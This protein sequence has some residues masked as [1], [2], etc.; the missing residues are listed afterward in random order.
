M[1]DY[2]GLDISPGMYQY[3]TKRHSGR[4]PWGSGDD[5]YQHEEHFLKTIKQMRANGMTEK[6]IWKS[7]GMT[8]SQY[9]MRIREANNVVKRY[10]YEE[11]ARLR[12]K[13]VSLQAIASRF[14]TNESSVRGWLNED[15]R[16]RVLKDK[17]SENVE[18]LKKDLA[19]KGGY[20]QI[21]SGV[22]LML[23]LNNNQ[24]RNVLNKLRQDGYVDYKMR[25]EQL[26]TG[27]YTNVQVLV[28]PNTSWAE[29]Q[30][31]MDKVRIPLFNSEDGGTTLRRIEPP[32]SVDSKRVDIRYAEQGGAEQDGMV[33]LRRGVDDISLKD[34]KYAQ[35]RIAVDGTHYIKGVAVY[36]DDK[37]FPPG[38]DIIFCTNKHEGT[39]MI[40]NSSPDRDKCVLKPMKN[41]P[42]N[43]FGATIKDDRP[44]LEKPLIRAQRHYIDA[45]GKEQ[46][47]CLNI[48]SEEGDR[49][50]WNNKLASQFLGKQNSGLAKNQ[51]KLSEQIA[52]EEFNELKSLTN[53]AVREKLMNEFAD[54]CDADAVELQA[55]GL[56][57]QS[58]ACIL[59]FPS[60]KEN[61]IYAPQ[62]RD[63]EHVALVRYPHGGIFEIPVCTVNNRNKEA[64]DTLGNVIDAVGI[65]KKTADRLSG[66]DFDGDTVLV[67]P[68]DITNI[69]TH[70]ALE[71]LKNFDPKTEYPGYEGMHVMTKSEKGRAMGDV[72]NLITDMTIKGAD[73][74]EIAAATRHSMVVIDAEKHKLDYQKSYV[75]NHIAELK[76]LYQGGARAGAS[77]LLSKSTSEE[78]VDQR[79]EKPL[80]RMTPEERKLY[81]EGHKIFEKTGDTYNAPKPSRKLMTAEEKIKWDSKDK[82]K[83]QE[84]LN[85]MKE[86]GDLAWKT[87]KKQDT[88]TKMAET[89]DAYTLVS[90]DS[91]GSTT[92]IE[93]VYADYANYMKALA[94]E[95]RA[96]ARN[97]QPT[98][99]SPSARKTYAV[100]V[101]SLNA[102]LEKA[103]LNSPRERQAMIKANIAYRSKVREDPTMDAEHKKRLKGQELDAARRM[104]G[105]KKA[106]IAI[107][108]R[109]WEA[110]T[111]GA[112]KKSVVRSILANA[113]PD[114]VKELAM[115]KNAPLMTTGKI[116]KAKSMLNAGYSQE[117]IARALGVSRST[118]VRA[119]G[120]G[121]Y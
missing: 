38:K 120:I 15:R 58:T 116:A 103:K 25:V 42:D 16:S 1:A 99:Y 14:N 62:Y 12:A 106:T 95:A 63:G 87:V 100:E 112:F 43:P 44:E 61:D 24:M 70:A 105:A 49:F 20:L 45:D 107:T 35:V 22:D 54:K 108:D 117:D 2:K 114:R 56:P 67:I 51:L 11:A 109:E 40:D 102:K 33:L 65:N 17:V 71:G 80:F 91:D 5:P 113:N 57:R 8:S 82:A 4:Y 98:D 64:A 60:I 48:V 78:H 77:T 29:V 83:Q 115:P 50:N 90:R 21:G 110:I 97:E 53:S 55:A 84:V 104:V 66:A 75:D 47:S 92:R 94:L 31:N 19:E 79:E 18:L 6:D 28:P 46:L 26:G 74:D 34:A 76:E 13:G 118:L 121:E 93:R 27:H 73:W 101:A 10:K 3:G 111:M 9:R 86:R 96:A 36:G 41:D 88:S 119:V 81:Y 89:D 30:N 23:G 37:E 72:T 69:K 32:K 7:F 39:P 68:C 59:G 52:R 85:A